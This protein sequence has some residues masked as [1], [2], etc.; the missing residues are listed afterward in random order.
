MVGRDPGV[1]PPSVPNRIIVAE[2]PFVV[3][4]ERSENPV[5]VT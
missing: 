2:A 1:A 4:I 5:V 3:S